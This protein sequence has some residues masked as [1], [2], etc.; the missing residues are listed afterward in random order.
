MTNKYNVS[1]KS[2]DWLSRK[3]NLIELV[4]KLVALSS[5]KPPNLWH[6]KPLKNQASE[7]S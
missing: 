1:D 7:K 5:K 6:S 3:N 2:S 4:L